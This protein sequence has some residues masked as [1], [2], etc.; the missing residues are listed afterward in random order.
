MKFIVIGYMGCKTVYVN[1]G[2]EEA[3][4][5]YNAIEKDSGVD[6]ESPL[7]EEIEISGDEFHVYDIWD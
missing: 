1:I 6:S 4:K 5:R 7:I 2:K 3:I